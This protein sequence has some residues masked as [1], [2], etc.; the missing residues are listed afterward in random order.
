MSA[1]SRVSDTGSSEHPRSVGN[2]VCRS[3]SPCVTGSRLRFPTASGGARLATVVVQTLEMWN[4]RC[5]VLPESGSTVLPDLG[6]HGVPVR[7]TN[8]LPESVSIYRPLDGT[9]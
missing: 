8:R 2:R 9:Q 6:S 5:A 7:R 4:H 1:T 3:R